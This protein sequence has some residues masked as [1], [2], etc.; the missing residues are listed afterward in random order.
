MNIDER[1]MLRCLELARLGAGAVSPNPMVGSVIVH[2]GIIIGEGWHQVYGGPHAEVNAINSVT[3]KGL[4]KDATVYVNLEPCSHYGK[5]PPCADL[6]VKYKVKEVVVGM[7]DPFAAVS[8]AGIR[9]LEV[10]GITVKV[11]ILEG[12]CRELNKRF[13]TYHTKQRPYI[14]LKWAQ[15][16]DGMMAPH[17]SAMNRE[18][19]DEKRRIT[20]PVVQMLVHK[21]R[22]EEDSILVGTNTVITDNPELNTRAYPGKNPL[23][24]TLD[25]TG[26]LSSDAT[27]FD[28]R[29]PTLIFTENNTMQSPSDQITYQLIDFNEPVW[30]QIFTGLYSRGIQSVIVEGGP[31]VLRSLIEA[32]LWDEAQVFRTSI[33]MGE[34]IF[35][36]IISGTI[37]LT[38]K[39]ENTELTI[40]SN[41]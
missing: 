32:G 26:N 36:P 38:S 28:G 12:H 3:D 37:N 39:I 31:T 34:G 17:A 7:V 30:Q 25:R 35:A 41:A 5:T 24:I 21:W 33:V 9:K 22:G 10:N 13:I 27:F 1:Y 18:V 14:I 19:F 16:S 6:L 8:G 40:Y 23:R 4:L 11:G 29:Q 2:N 20:G 15:T